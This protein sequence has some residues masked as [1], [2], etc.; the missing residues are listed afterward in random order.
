[1]AYRGRLPERGDAHEADE[2][3][4]AQALEAV[5]DAVRPEDL[6]HRHHPAAG[7][8]ADAVVELKE[9]DRRTLQPREAL[10]QALLDLARDVLE[11][12]DVQA[13]LGGD[14]GLGAGFRQEP[15]ERLLRL[16][17]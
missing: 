16:P 5:G 3:I 15:A 2:V 4:V 17:V 11:V 13:E 9:V 14:E 12:L 6:L 1:L 8:R 10:A 7:F